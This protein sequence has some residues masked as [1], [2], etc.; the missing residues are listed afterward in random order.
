M[1]ELRNISKSFGR[2]SVLRDVSLTFAPGCVHGL[3]G[4]NGAGK[5]TL[6]NILFGLTAPDAGEILLDG[7]AVRIGSPRV[8]QRLGIGMVHQH[9][10]LVPTLSTTE[11]LSLAARRP[12][13]AVKARAAEWLERLGWQL[14]M[15]T[16]AGRLSVGQQQRAE[17]LKALL[18]TDLS[19]GTVA[20]TLIL[21]EPT[22]VLTPQEVGELFAAMRALKASGAAVRDE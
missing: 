8:A 21:D 9:F 16:A 4:E 19:G 17:I 10:K 2:V 12:G 3:L 15:Q 14:P 20:R 22:A 18:T 11:N 6:M 1:L 13:R 5:S 7:R